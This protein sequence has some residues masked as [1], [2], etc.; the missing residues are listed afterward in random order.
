MLKETIPIYERERRVFSLLRGTPQSFY[1]VVFKAPLLYFDLSCFLFAIFTLNS[2]AYI[3][4]STQG[5][6]DRILVLLN[7][8]RSCHIYNK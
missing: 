4:C 6:H 8:R 5:N 1:Y 3:G 7:Q 2:K